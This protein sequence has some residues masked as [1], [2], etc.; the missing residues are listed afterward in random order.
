MS[1]Y[2]VFSGPY[3]P[4]YGLKTEYLSE[5]IPNARK[6]GPEKTPYLDTFHAVMKKVLSAMG[7]FFYLSRILLR[8]YC[9]KNVKSGGWEKDPTEAMAR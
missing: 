7:L 4:A 6:Y 1:K 3:F 9:P 8:R 5:L 2:A